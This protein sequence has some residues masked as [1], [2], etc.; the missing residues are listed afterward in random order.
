MTRSEWIELVVIA[1]LAPVCWLVW[2][3]FPTAMPLWQI[4]L[5]LSALLLAQSLAR[6]ITILLGSR[7]STAIAPRKEAQC[8]CMESTV[9]VT[10]VVA[11][12]SLAA[13][14]VSTHVVI[15]QWGFCLALLATMSMGIA[16]KDLVISWNPFG[17][18]REKDHLNLIVRWKSTKRK[19]DRD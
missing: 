17:L 18:R 1:V 13:L 5:K 15:P 11:G 3:R 16:I 7:M 12:I 14:G 9:G 6:D 19:S 10:G 8:F 4:V 2:P